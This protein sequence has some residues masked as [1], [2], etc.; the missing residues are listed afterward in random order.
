MFLTEKETTAE[1]KEPNIL[2]IQ[3][4]DSQQKLAVLTYMKEN[5]IKI[6]CKHANYCIH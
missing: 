6:K 4:Q 2:A 5:Q 3:A 1:D